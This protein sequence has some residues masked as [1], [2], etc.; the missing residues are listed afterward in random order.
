MIFTKGH[1]RATLVTGVMTALIRLALLTK[2]HFVTMGGVT[3]QRAPVSALPGGQGML[4][5]S[6]QSPVQQTVPMKF[7]EVVTLSLEL[8]C[9]TRLD[10]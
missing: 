2:N 10:R 1:A 8:V 3:E 6:L 7:R 5:I 9:A 4:V